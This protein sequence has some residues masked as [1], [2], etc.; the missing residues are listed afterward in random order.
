MATL[1]EAYEEAYASVSHDVILLHA[2]EINHPAFDEPLRVIQWPIT[3]NEPDKFYCLH[4]KDATY[5]P[6]KEVLYVG[7][8]YT[9]TLPESSPNNEGTLKIEIAIYNDFD[10]Y[11]Y[12][13][14]LNPGIIKAI[15]RTYIKGREKEGPVYT[16]KDLTISNPSR[17]GGKIKAD[18]TVLGWMK[19]P[20][21]KLYQPID[22]PALERGR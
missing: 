20:F 17:E 2:L 19:K 5:N 18:G 1:E 16:W 11:L 10:R 13:A 12:E 6:G 8:P 15:Y 3:G 21:G 4:E 14:A 22:Y 7:F 9:M